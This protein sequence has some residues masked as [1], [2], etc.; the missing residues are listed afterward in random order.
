M[1]GNDPNLDLANLNVYIKFGE[2]YPS[3]DIKPK[4]NSD[5]HQGQ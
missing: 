3:Q 5:I 4:R 2:I 1:T